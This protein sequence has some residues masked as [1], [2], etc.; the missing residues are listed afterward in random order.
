MLW[1]L[2]L[3]ASL[4]GC[5][6]KAPTIPELSTGDIQWMTWALATWTEI[7]WTAL[8]G[9]IA[10]TISGEVNTS[11]DSGIV[12]VVADSGEVI[13]QQSGVISE[14]KKLIE[15]RNTQAKDEKK[16]NEPDI[17]FMQKVIDLFK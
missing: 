2:L 10:P 9:I 12:P 3:S 14:V 7:S 5:S 8:S 15:E 11:F 6:F 16:L 17:D 1:L 13:A 4:A